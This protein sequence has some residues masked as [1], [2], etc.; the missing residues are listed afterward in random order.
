MEKT[1]KTSMAGKIIAIAASVLMI[2]FAFG[3]WLDIRPMKESIRDEYPDDYV[4]SVLD[5][6]KDK[7][8]L[9]EIPEILEKVGYYEDLGDLGDIDKFMNVP[10][11]AVGLMLFLGILNIVF[12]WYSYKASKVMTIISCILC[13]SMS[14]AFIGAVAFFNFEI[15]VIAVDAYLP[16]KLL[17]TTFTPYCIVA[18]SVIACIAVRIKELYKE[19]ASVAFTATPEMPVAPTPP[20]RPVVPADPKS[21]TAAKP[22]AFSEVLRCEKCGNVVEAGD[23]FCNKCGNLIKK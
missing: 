14:A 7:Y 21:N 6:F 8:S 3:K 16:D 4:E 19:S 23:K 20:V 9:L 2:I 12:A 11:I 13:A 15:K 5:E 22:M 17:K 10:M 18:L 1:V